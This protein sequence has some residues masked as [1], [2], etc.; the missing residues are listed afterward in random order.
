MRGEP[1]RGQSLLD[2]FCCSGP[3]LVEACISIP[4]ISDHSLV[5]ANC[6]LEA[7][8]DKRSPGKVCRWSEEIG[9]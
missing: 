7:T 1:A 4:G 9:N 3:S 8:I 6:D 2:L 5:L